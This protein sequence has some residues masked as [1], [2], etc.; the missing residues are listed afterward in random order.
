MREN[1]CRRRH[2]QSISYQKGELSFFEDF[3]FTLT[4]VFFRSISRGQLKNLT[5][6]WFTP[7]LTRSF[8]KGNKFSLHNE[9]LVSWRSQM[10]MNHPLNWI[11]AG[12]LLHCATL[13]SPSLGTMA[14]C[15]TEVGMTLPL[16]YCSFPWR[17]TSSPGMCVNVGIS[18]TS[19]E[20]MYGYL[21]TNWY[22]H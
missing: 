17:L 8:S 20:E 15:Q 7:P 1:W 5:F 19:P 11:L 12:H 9:L 2:S 22:N 10:H 6:L 21:R 18:G 16:A 13:P 14:I 4:R 3:F